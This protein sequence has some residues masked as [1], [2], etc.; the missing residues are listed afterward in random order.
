M[1]RT[2]S[3]NDAHSMDMLQE[4]RDHSEPPEYWEEDRRQPGAMS[5]GK[6]SS[7]TVSRP[8]S[9]RTAA[10]WTLSRPTSA[11][12]PCTYPSSAKA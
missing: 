9:P 2:I 1:I 12:S 4:Q 7:S 6:S 5:C 11:T 8:T 3:I 10:A